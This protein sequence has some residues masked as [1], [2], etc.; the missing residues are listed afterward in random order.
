[1]GI[2]AIETEYNGY[3]FRSRLEARWAVFLDALGVKY[4]YEPEGFELPSGKK[5]LPDFKVKCH[6][7]RGSCSDEPFDLYIEVKG[8]M[9]QDDADKIREFAGKHENEVY[10]IE[11]E[12]PVLIVGGIPPKDCSYDSNALGAYDGMDGTDVY[13]FNYQLVD[14]DMFAAYPAAK[15]GRFYLWGD[16]SNYIDGIDGVENAY[17][18]ARKARF[19]YG[20]VPMMPYG[21]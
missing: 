1:M 13:P 18:I 10:E 16:D 7:K 8:R 20:E 12:N 3:R 15:N 19:E 6:G 5:Y 9:T 11:I 2:K 4:E 21:R 14:G 17:D